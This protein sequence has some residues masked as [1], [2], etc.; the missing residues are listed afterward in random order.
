LNS[1]CK[2]LV[3]LNRLPEAIRVAYGALA[4]FKRL[5]V[6]DASGYEPDLAAALGTVGRLQLMLDPHDDAFTRLPNIG[7]FL[8]ARSAIVEAIRIYRR[9]AT[10]NP[11]DYEPFLAEMLSYYGKQASTHGR[12]LLAE[13]EF[14]AAPDAGVEA[15]GIYRRLAAAN[16]ATY[17]PR[18]VAALDNLSSQFAE[19]GQHDEAL[20]VAEDA[21]EIHRRLAVA[22]PAVHQAGVADALTAVAERQL[23]LGRRDE[24]LS[25]V[26]EA[27][28]I[29]RGLLNVNP[30]Q[31]LGP[32]LALSMMARLLAERGR[33]EEAFR[34]L[35]H[36]VALRRE[37]ATTN[38]SAHEPHL[39]GDLRALGNVL[40][41][42]G[43]HDGASAALREAVEIYRRLAAANRRYADDLR[44]A[45]IDLGSE[46]PVAT[47]NAV[48]IELLKRHVLHADEGVQRVKEWPDGVAVTTTIGRHLVGG[49]EPDELLIGQEPWVRDVVVAIRDDLFIHGQP[50]RFGFVLLADGG[51]IYVNSA[52]DVAE[53]GRRLADGMNPAAYAEILVQFHPYTSA[54]RTVLTEA[55]ELRRRFARAELPDN[56]PI[57]LRQM[58]EGVVL[59]FDS[60]IQYEK[61]GSVLDDPLALYRSVNRIALCDIMSWTITVPYGQPAEWTSRLVAEGVNLDP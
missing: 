56:N 16:P 24:A 52:A 25:S 46:Q 39:A 10:A 7:R 33:H 37:L 44:Q 50:E 53:L 43:H 54:T 18:L 32:A 8:A 31:E 40:R 3:P 60:L 27:V 61:P 12:E 58:P 51:D 41:L 2:Q 5:A 57:R 19:L 55:G 42:V 14:A 22:N 15:V 11:I 17:E 34:H 49:P 13:D 35:N 30:G 9:L 4:I 26:T 29:H 59:T 23:A 48:I 47:S 21:L 38:P 1:L 20:S 36:A 6:S 28:D 45:L